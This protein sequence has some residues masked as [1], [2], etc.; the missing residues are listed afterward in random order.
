M[1]THC[2]T[3]SGTPWPNTQVD[4]VTREGVSIL[5]GALTAD[6]GVY[7]PGQTWGEISFNWEDLG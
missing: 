7:V 4:H 3:R 2:F 1:A 6:A 5:G